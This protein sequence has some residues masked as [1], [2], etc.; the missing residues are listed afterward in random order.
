MSTVVKCPQLCGGASERRPHLEAFTDLHSLTYKINQ[1]FSQK[2]EH[3][4]EIQSCTDL[5]C[6]IKQCEK[7]LPSDTPLRIKKKK[8]RRKKERKENKK[9]KERKTLSSLF[10]QICCSNWDD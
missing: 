1:N 2:C 8:K 4:T 5:F 3:F 10:K 6:H 7:D 9:K